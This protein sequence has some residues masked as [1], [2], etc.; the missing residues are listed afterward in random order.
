MYSLTA[1][2]DNEEEL[3]DL[4]DRTAKMLDVPSRRVN[5]SAMVRASLRVMN[6]YTSAVQK[7]IKPSRWKTFLVCFV[8]DKGWFKNYN[9][10]QSR[11]EALKEQQAKL[12]L[13]EIQ[14]VLSDKS[15]FQEPTEELAP[16]QEVH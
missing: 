6:A 16:S 3:L 11:E 7:H 14:K 8:S 4:E 15:F 13:D 10:E 12:I 9:W 5:H 2:I 1:K